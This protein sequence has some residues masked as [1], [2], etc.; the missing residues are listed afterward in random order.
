MIDGLGIRSKKIDTEKLISEI[1]N[2]KTSLVKDYEAL[3]SKVEK[4][5]LIS[6]HASIKAGMKN[7]EEDLKN[8][9]KKKSSIRSK[10]EKLVGFI[11][12]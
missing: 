5:T 12:G 8:L 1:Q 9:E 10:I 11:K 6:S 2:D 7:L 4:F 3:K